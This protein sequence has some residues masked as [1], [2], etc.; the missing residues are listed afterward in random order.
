MARSEDFDIRKAAK[1]LEP[2]VFFFNQLKEWDL[3]ERCILLRQYI[4]DTWDMEQ[5]LEKRADYIQTET[6][7]INELLREIRQN[8]EEDAESD[9]DTPS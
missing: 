9:E 5:R 3:A 2:A 6:F 7:A 1:L 4:L 8:L